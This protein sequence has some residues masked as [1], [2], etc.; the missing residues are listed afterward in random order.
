MNKVAYVWEDFNHPKLRELRDKYKLEEVVSKGKDEFEKQLLLKDWVFNKLKLGYNNTKW[1]Q[2]S[3]EVLEDAEK[4]EEFNCTWY[5]LVF[6]QCALSLGWYARKLG[7]D[8]DHKFGQE[9]MRHTA[10][11]I[12][13][14][15]FN[16]WFVVDPMFNAHFEVH[17]IPQNALEI[18]KCRID[19]LEI[20][21][22]FG[23][24]EEE[25]L[26]DR[27]KDRH[28]LPENYYWIMVYLRNN[29]LEDQNISSSHTLLWIDEYNKN[30]KWYVGGQHKGEFREH[31]MYQGAFIKTSDYNLFYPDM[32]Q[33]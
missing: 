5:V 12:W 28:D 31:P 33:K 9:E 15:K 14:S 18:R 7:I 19:N 29:F 3:F 23:K 26:S 32:G 25:K 6:L 8:T 20:E 22:V 24:Y 2:N 13:S 17:H 21:K 30:K 1:Y 27:I 11:E 16:K 4:G 10:V